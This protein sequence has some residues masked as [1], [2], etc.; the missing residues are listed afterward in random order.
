MQTGRAILVLGDAPLSEA[1]FE[2]AATYAE[3]FVL[4]RAVP[5]RAASFVV[6]DELADRRARQRLRQVA[7]RLATRGTRVRGHVGTADADA[8]RRDALA[9]F[10]QPSMVLEAA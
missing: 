4:A 3:V 9:L 6:D 7:A 10:P 8:A 5:D 1:S 2:E